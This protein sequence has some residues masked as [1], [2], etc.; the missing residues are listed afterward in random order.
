MKVFIFWIALALASQAGAVEVDCF[1]AKN[2]GA[3]FIAVDSTELLAVAADR[4]SNM[5]PV[6][7]GDRACVLTVATVHGEKWVFVRGHWGDIDN[8]PLQ[9]WLPLDAIV[10]RNK[11]IRHTN[12]R[13]QAVDVEIGD[14]FAQ[15]TVKKGGAFEVQQAVS[16]HKCR[17]SEIPN[18]YGACE[19][20][21][22]VRGYFYGK[23]MLAI[24]ISE[25][26]GEFDILKLA[27]DG[28]LCP[29]QYGNP[30]DGCR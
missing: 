16:E 14:Y 22:V 6:S 29:W 25:K 27:G 2:D 24:A 12:V 9:G 1:R 7:L 30:P 5:T 20:V 15:Y 28:T 8:R 17:K 4:S 23:G 21:V 26:Y 10:Y 11:L 3:A 13:V 18:E 19:D